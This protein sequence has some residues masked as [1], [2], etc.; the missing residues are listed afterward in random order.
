MWQ[1]GVTFMEVMVVITVIT[2]MVVLGY[3]S[4]RQMMHSMESKRVRSYVM[5][6]LKEAR[7]LSFTERQ[8]LI[9]CLANE[10]NQCHNRAT[11]K[12]ILFKDNDDNQRF[13]EGELLKEYDLNAKYG[14]IEMNVSA[15]RHYMR[16]FG[17]TG[18]PRGHFGHIKYCSLQG[19]TRL[20]HKTT[21]TAVGYVWVGEGC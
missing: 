20:N 5:M 1:K 3:P 11:Q 4:F 18:V 6:A 15:R 19:Q 14:S 13:D 17:D 2:I 8:N 7:M 21:I 10:H 9:V 16:Y 12:V